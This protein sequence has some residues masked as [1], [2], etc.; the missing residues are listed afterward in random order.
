M[1]QRNHLIGS[2]AD[3]VRRSLFK[4]REIES[5]GELIWLM[6]PDAVESQPRRPWRQELDRVSVTK[7][8]SPARHNF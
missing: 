7:I 3:R 4:R 8:T 5:Y 1:K 2:A 6:D